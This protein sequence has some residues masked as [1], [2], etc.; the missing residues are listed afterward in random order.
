MSRSANGRDERRAERE[1][2]KLFTRLMLIRGII[3]QSGCCR[4]RRFVNGLELNAHA[5][6]PQCLFRKWAYRP[7]RASGLLLFLSLFLSLS[8]LRFAHASEST[9]L[10]SQSCDLQTALHVLAQ[11]IVRSEYVS[12]HLI[13]VFVS[14][15]LNFQEPSRLNLI[16]LDIKSLYLHLYIDLKCESFSNKL[17]VKI[18]IKMV[19]TVKVYSVVWLDISSNNALCMFKLIQVRCK[20]T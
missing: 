6:S 11:A 4:R 20:L 10:L 7:T 8:S 2:A 12:I 14:L 13:K 1:R 17:L 3:S 9:S 15:Q 19:G 16:N 5:P 18:Q